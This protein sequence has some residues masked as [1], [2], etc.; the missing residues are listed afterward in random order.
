MADKKTWMKRAKV[1]ERQVREQRESLDGAALL[2]FDLVNRLRFDGQEVH[3]LELLL[4]SVTVSGV[5]ILNDVDWLD[6]EQKSFERI[7]SA[8][9]AEAWLD[10]NGYELVMT[11]LHAPRGD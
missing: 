3:F 6:H 5:E 2:L 4:R 9:D 10:A 1:A 8:M 7:A 11:A